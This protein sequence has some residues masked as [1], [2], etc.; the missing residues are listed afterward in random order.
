[1]VKKPLSVHF[2]KKILDM[3]QEISVLMKCKTELMAYG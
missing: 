1:M 3:E 2:Q